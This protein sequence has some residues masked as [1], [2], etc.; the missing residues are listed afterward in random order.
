[1]TGLSEWKKKKKNVWQNS[2]PRRIGMIFAPDQRTAIF[3]FFSRP[4][5]FSFTIEAQ[6]KAAL[7]PLDTI[8]LCD[9]LGV[10]EGP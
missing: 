2:R 1:M 9:V 4:R 5:G 7:K 3:G 10:S 8:V 6:L